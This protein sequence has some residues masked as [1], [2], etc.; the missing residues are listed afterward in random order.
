MFVHKVIVSEL[1]EIGNS[2]PVLFDKV[3]VVRRGAFVNLFL[4][5]GSYAGGHSEDNDKQ[6]RHD[7]G[8]VEITGGWDWAYRGRQ[9]DEGGVDQADERDGTYDP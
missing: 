9:M 5:R 3:Y 1:V 6:T 8:L 7:R 2:T 4:V